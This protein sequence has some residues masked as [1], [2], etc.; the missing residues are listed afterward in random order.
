MAKEL[1]TVVVLLT[2][3]NRSLEQ[4]TNKRPMPSDSRDTGQIEQDCDYWLGIHRESVYDPDA[5]KTLTELILRLNRHGKTGTVYVDQKGLSISPVDQH[6]ATAKSQPQKE[7]K[8]YS[9]KKF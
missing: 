6:V 3:L 2:Q 8:R 9:D 7:P 4:R 1:N 5:D